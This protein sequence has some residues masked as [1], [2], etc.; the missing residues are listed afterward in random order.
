VVPLDRKT[1]QDNRVIYEL[2]AS[3]T[4][5]TTTYAGVGISTDENFIRPVMWRKQVD[6]LFVDGVMMSKERNYLEP[7]IF[8]TSG[9]IKSIS[10]N[11]SKIYIKDSWMFKKVDDLGDSFQDVT[12]VGLGETAVVEKIE[13]CTY[14]GDYGI[15]VGIGTSAVGINTTKPAL[16]FEI[17]PNPGDY[18]DGVDHLGIYLDDGIP[19]GNAKFYRS[20]SGITTGDYFVIDNT[21]IGDGV[22]GI[23]T[24]SSGPETVGVGNSFLNGV[25]FAEHYV[26]VGSSVLRVFANVDSIAGIDTTT[27]SNNFKFGTYSW[28]S[29]SGTRKNGKPFTFHN[30]NG[31][32]GIETSAQVIRTEELSTFYNQP[33]GTET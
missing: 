23:K 5:E 20:V 31:L 13:D 28:G 30:Q 21:F 29:V 16:F 15:V 22:T 1:E 25:Y 6:D 2:I 14:E 26:S 11:D 32:L 4:V 33:D 8:P 3:D 7:Q 18:Q 17:M 9:I 12:I 27:L 19:A 24:T 10:S